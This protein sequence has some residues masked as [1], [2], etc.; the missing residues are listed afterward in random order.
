MEKLF[1]AMIKFGENSDL[2]V[3]DTD[4][5]GKTSLVSSVALVPLSSVDLC[6]FLL[7]KE[8]DKPFLI[9]LGDEQ[10]DDDPGTDRLV[11]IF[12]CCLL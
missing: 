2:I 8:R 3:C 10:G 7:S 1:F 9:R 6:R 12:L 5:L 11:L 4:S